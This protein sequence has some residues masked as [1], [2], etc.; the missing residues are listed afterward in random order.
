MDTT[1]DSAPQA[2]A[3]HQ[4]RRIS[5]PIKILIS[6]VFAMA[7]VIAILQIVV[8]LFLAQPLGANAYVSF[9]AAG[10]GL[11]LA[12]VEQQLHLHGLAQIRLDTL[13][14]QQRLTVAALA[15]LCATCNAL[16][17]NHLRRLFDLYSRGQV[18]T[19]N[20]I[21]HLKSFGMWLVVAAIVVNV[22]GRL[23]VWLTHAAVI[24]TSNAALMVVLGAMIYVIAYVMELGREAD[25]ERKEFL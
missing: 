18:F 14:I 8:M 17:L 6:I 12:D 22:A 5:Q 21:R 19:E 1:L 24:S 9:S 2:R 20:N 15:V 10:V 16:A 25:L 23:F 11:N 3:L 7:I 13:S 4:I